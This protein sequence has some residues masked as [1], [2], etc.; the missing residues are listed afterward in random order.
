MQQNTIPYVMSMTAEDKAVFETFC[1]DAGVTVSKL[2]TGSL[3]RL[4]DFILRKS[5]EAAYLIMEKSS[6]KPAPAGTRRRITS[7]AAP[8]RA[9]GRQRRC[10]R[11]HRRVEG[12]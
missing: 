9:V 7:L 5:E 6:R 4:I 10:D 2:A 8:I 11:A 3:E 1:N 12:L